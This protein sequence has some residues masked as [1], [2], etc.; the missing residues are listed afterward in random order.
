VERD[1]DREDKVLDPADLAES[2]QP[3]IGHAV[4]L[5]PLRP[6]DQDIELAFLNELSP[7][8]RHNRLLGGAIR[9]TKEYVERLT[10]VDLSRDMALAATVMIEDRETLI[11]VA[12]YV[13]D[14]E[15]RSCEFA[16]VIADAWQGRGI[17]RRLMLKLIA[18]ARTR[19]LAQIYGDVLS[20]NL[21]MLNFCRTLGFTM[22]HHPGDPTVTR[23]TLNLA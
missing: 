4:T 1:P 6:A 13:R 8:T 10:T 19:G 18:L 17:G 11:G 22:S 20:S 2:F 3:I 5:R 21:H 12:R 15:A 14:A 16:I 7:E 9:I 23:V